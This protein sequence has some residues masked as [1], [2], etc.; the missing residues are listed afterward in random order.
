M[1]RQLISYPKIFFRSLDLRSQI[2]KRIMWI[3]SKSH[4]EKKFFFDIFAIHS[5]SRHEKC[6][7]MS[8]R[9]LSL[10][11]GSIYQQWF[12]SQAFRFTRYVPHYK[13]VSSLEGEFYWKTFWPLFK[14]GINFIHEPS[15]LELFYYFSNTF[16]KFLEVTTF[17]LYSGAWF[18][19]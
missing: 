15:L 6:C 11:R 19:H 2:S 5:S 16:C 8:V 14:S 1:L 17:K 4:R 3:I 12:A 10:F 18:E 9:L 13:C 7:Q